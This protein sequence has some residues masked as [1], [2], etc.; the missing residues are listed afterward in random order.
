MK[1]FTFVPSNRFSIDVMNQ[2]RYCP[3]TKNVEIDLSLQKKETPVKYIDRITKQKAELIWE[4]GENVLA[5]HVAFFVGRRLISMPKTEEDAKKTLALYS[6]RN[7][8]VYAGIFLK[9][10]DGTT[11]HKRTFTRIKL[12]HLDS[13]ATDEFIASNEWQNQIGGYNPQGI[14]QKHIIKIVGSHTGF[15]GLPCYETQNLIN[16]M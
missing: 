14:M 16:Q 6:G 2:M 3:Q 13:K 15:F 8:V 7:H 4:Q 12:R 5:C 10:S 11:S 9:K 1:N